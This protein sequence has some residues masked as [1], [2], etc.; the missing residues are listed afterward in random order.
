M[1]TLDQIDLFIKEYHIINILLFIIGWM[2][3]D[4]YN[5]KKS[6]KPSNEQLAIVNCNIKKANKL[7]DKQQLNYMS[8]NRLK[9][10]NS[11]LLKKIRSQSIFIENKEKELSILVS[12]NK[13]LKNKV[14]NL[15]S[16][17]MKKQSYDDV[18]KPKF[19]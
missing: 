1:P 13:F 14:D 18:K 6:S 10:D 16:E 4:L 11:L 9:E 19:L 8:I 3:Y 15:V 7:I 17:L 2:T 5:L 12:E